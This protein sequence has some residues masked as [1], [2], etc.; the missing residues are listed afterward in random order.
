MILVI[1]NYDSFTYNL[2]HYLNELGADTVVHRNDDLSVQEALGLRPQ[3][4]LLSPG[5]KAPDQA[6]ICLPLLRGAPDDLA[7]LGVCLGHQAIGQAYGGDVIRAKEVMHGKTSKIFHNDQGVFKGLPNPFI[8]TR[9]HSLAV[10]KATLPD[11]LEITAWTEDGEIMGVQHK[12]RPVY[13]V[14]FHPES[15][16]TEG[17]HQLLANFLD[18]AKVQRDAAIWV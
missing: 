17:G 7:I 1:D 14:Q 4:V 3:A 12:T 8:A 6:G 16:A 11:D 2:V 5:P 9:Y 13:G 10:D 18:L 15:I